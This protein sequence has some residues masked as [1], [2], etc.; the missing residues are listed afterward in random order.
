MRTL[1]P[2]QQSILNR[3]VDT[4]I[5]TGQP[6]GSGA[7]TVLFRGLYGN[8][9]SP[10]TVRHEMGCLEEC[11]YLTHPHTSAGRVPTDLG[12]RY[13]VDHGLPREVP[14]DFPEKDTLE[15]LNRSASRIDSFTQAASRALSVCS[16]ELSLVI[17]MP[18]SSA[19]EYGEQ[20]CHVY[21]HGTS[22]MLAK[23]EFQEGEKL[24]GLFQ[25]IEEK[26]AVVEWLRNV[27]ADQTDVAVTIGSENHIGAFHDCSVFSAAYAIQRQIAGIV[28]VIGA[29]RIRYSRMISLVSGM[30]AL[31]ERIL[32]G[33]A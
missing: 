4:H 13:Y 10:A 28:A 2:R 23:P 30:R 14:P 16:D 15:S 18:R 9:Y 1:S 7:I 6:V 19:Q 11:G 31:I 24:Q 26:T 27:M 17:A 22:R 32:E 20:E 25:A 8:S 12:Y 5:E 21:V 29:R 3:V 33:R